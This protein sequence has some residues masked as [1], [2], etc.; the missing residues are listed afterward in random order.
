MICFFFLRP[1]VWVEQKDTSVEADI[2][3]YVGHVTVSE[4]IEAIKDI[5]RRT[6]D[7]IFG[8]VTLWA[9]LVKLE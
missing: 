5:G 6:F 2:Q 7:I 8:K 4:Q 1:L 3:Q 9:K